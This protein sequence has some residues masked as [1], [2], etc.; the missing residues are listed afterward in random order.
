MRLLVKSVLVVAAMCMLALLGAWVM[1]EW[2]VAWPVDVEAQKILAIA[3]REDHDPPPIVG[4]VILAE[5]RDG[6][7][8]SIQVARQLVTRVFVNAARSQGTWNSRFFLT[9][10][11]CRNLPRDELVGLYATL[12]YNGVDHGVNRLSLR[13]FGK[14]LHALS[15]DEAITLEAIL[16]SPNYMLNDPQHLEHR[17]AVLLARLNGHDESTGQPIP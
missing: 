13:R 9:D 10:L 3:D 7:G 2:F 17:R 11:A 6:D 14:P 12:V 1:F 16:W 4:R 8:L 15:E 5:F